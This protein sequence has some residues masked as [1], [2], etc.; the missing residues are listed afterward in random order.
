MRINMEFIAGLV[1]GAFLGVAIMCL[2]AIAK[3][4]E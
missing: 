4:E 3:E 1:V 2:M